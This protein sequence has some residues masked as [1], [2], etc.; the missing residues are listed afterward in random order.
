VY[1][2]KALKAPIALDGNPSLGAWRTEGQHEEATMY[3]WVKTAKGWRIFWGVD[4]Y[5][6]PPEASQP[7]E[8][9]DATEDEAGEPEPVL[10]QGGEDWDWNG[11]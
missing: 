5:A 2:T 10:A 6:L 1:G 11:D 9:R 8:T 7:E 4:P 3:E